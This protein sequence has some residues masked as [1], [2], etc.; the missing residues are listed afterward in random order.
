MPHVEIGTSSGTRG[1]AR[2][3]LGAARLLALA[4]LAGAA[5]M[6]LEIVAPRMAAPRVGSGATAWVV[7]IATFLLG[8]ALGNRFGG[9]AADRRGPWLLPALFLASA[10]LTAVTRAWAGL[11]FAPFHGLSPDLRALVAVPIVF[12]PVTAL[13][14]TLPPAL[15]RDWLARGAR[16]GLR[17]GALAAA[18]ALGSVAGTFLAGYVLLPA[19]G[20]SGVLL[21]TATALLLAG[22]VA[23]RSDRQRAV[24]AAPVEAAPEAVPG[25]VGLGLAF[26]AGAAVLALEVLGGRA[27]SERLGAS[28]YTWTA[29]I[30]VVLAG[31]AIGGVL[32]GA[33]ADRLPPR[34]LLR[35]L[36]L[37][38]SIGAASLLWSPWVLS[39]ANTWGK[40]PAVPW[41][42]AVLAATTLA[43]LLPS[44]ALGTLSPVIIRAELGRPRDD[45]RVVGLYYAIGTLGAVA[46]AILVG[47]VLIPWAGRERLILCLAFGL[48]SVSGMIRG[49]Q[50][51]VLHL[52][53]V[54]LAMLIQGPFASLREAGRAMGLVEEP[55]QLVALED[56]RHARIRVAVAEPEISVRMPDELDIVK[57]AADPVL[58]WH[59][60]Y[61]EEAGRLRW[62]G[63]MSEAQ[64]QRLL[65]IVTSAA[66]K[67]SVEALHRDA[68]ESY[69]TL[70]IDRLTHGYVDLEDPAWLGYEY[71]RTY[72]AVLD[73]LG[74]PGDH[75]RCLFLGGGA[76]AFQRY[77]LAEGGPDLRVTTV[78]IDPW[79]TETARRYL[80]LADDPRHEIV[81]QDARTWVEDAPAGAGAYGLVIGDAFDHIAVP[82]QLTTLE[83][84]RALDRAMAPDGLY[85][86]NVVDAWD[87]GRFL[88]AMVETLRRVFPDVRVMTRRRPRTARDTYVIVA[89]KRRLDDLPASIETVLG[90]SAWVAPE[91]DVLELLDR[92]GH[93]L[94]TDDDA[95]V[96]TLLA[97]VVHPR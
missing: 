42:G 94:L 95:P 79:V 60:L 87:P 51:Y 85:L 2:A 5:A 86:V 89:S 16:P 69:R 72:A 45:G 73:R 19:L 76:Y 12:L 74:A 9:R 82:F 97:P 93:R 11:A 38:A 68:N 33:L 71:E 62:R 78:E 23:P 96:E 3:A 7:T 25:R 6:V 13:L 92:T 17:L 55:E 24:H 37:V 52:A 91:S 4:A 50:P 56:S 26:A 54:L 40:D 1:G 64:H 21:S 39:L 61:D 53:L 46:G 14:G 57:I 18:G 48:A 65:D 88:G 30:G 84:D 47:Y 22:L 66:G 75:G 58:D 90:A 28:I 77:L 10:V 36:F 35:W 27:A 67:V 29:V 49:R 81:H 15:A 80:G 59:A 83:F 34:R 20:I 44:I 43:L 70:W 41:A 63:P 31:L 32:G 8:L